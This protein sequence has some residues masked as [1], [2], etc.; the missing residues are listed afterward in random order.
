[1][2]FFVI[3]QDLI[4]LAIENVSMQESA[5]EQARLYAQMFNGTRVTHRIWS[6]F[7]FSL[8]IRIVFGLGILMAI[9][10]FA[11]N[12]TELSNGDS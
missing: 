3:K 2:T 6:L 10:I 8:E 5:Q 11:T 12:S 4:G 9:P 1:M 7:D